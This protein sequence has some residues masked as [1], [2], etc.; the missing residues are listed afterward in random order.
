M[1]S[2]KNMTKLAI[3]MLACL[4]AAACTEVSFEPAPV[5][6]FS[7]QG[8]LDDGVNRTEFFVF[9][10]DRPPSK[11]DVL[12]VV[13]NWGSMADEQKKLSTALSSVVETLEGLDWQ[14]AITT[15]DISGGK[16][17]T[18]GKIV[19]MV[20]TSAKDLNQ[21]VPNYE[22]VFIDTIV[23][24]GTPADC[25]G[26]CPSGTEQ[27]LQATRLAVDKRNTDNHGFFRANSDFVVISLSDEDEMSN[28][29]K[30]ATTPEQLINSVNAAWGM[31]KLF[32]GYGIIIRPGDASCLSQQ[33]KSGGVYGTYVQKLAD[34]TSAM[35]G[36]ICDNDYGPA[37]ANI[38]KGVRKFATSIVLSAVPVPGTLQVTM[39]PPHPAITWV[40]YGQ[41][42]RLSDIPAK[43][44]RVDVTYER[45]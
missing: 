10:E 42:V 1:G 20:G 36:S 44:T 33:S 7:Q 30:A 21:S 4:S 9:N 35:T 5:K 3:S 24:N 34:L 31:T 6:N 29:P 15:T 11:V 39:T 28:A 17:S 22:Q 8:P 45:L 41:T 25:T 27:P 40:L 16:Y 2:G 19:Q 32:S 12:F 14:V 26:G 37:L 43:G 23:A 38:G 18:N 13:D